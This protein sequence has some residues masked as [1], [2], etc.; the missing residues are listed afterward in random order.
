M[1]MKEVSTALKA[2]ARVVTTSSPA[3][4]T[5]VIPRKTA[6]TVVSK[7]TFTAKDLKTVEQRTGITLPA[8]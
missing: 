8:R 6:K 4:K 2:P 1:A 5:P 3:T 7:K